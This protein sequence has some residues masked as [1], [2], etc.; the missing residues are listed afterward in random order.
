MLEQAVH[1][2]NNAV[3][4]TDKQQSMNLEFV[5]RNTHY[6]QTTVST[7]KIK[8]WFLNCGPPDKIF[9]CFLFN[10]PGSLIPLGLSFQTMRK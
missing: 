1:D 10:R 8:N 4:C 5:R 7:R 6:D 9:L 2:G 3:K